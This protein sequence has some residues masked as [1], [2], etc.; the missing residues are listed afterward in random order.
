[1]RQEEMTTSQTRDWRSQ[2]KRIASILAIVLLV[3]FIALNFEKVDVDFLVA[4]QNIQLA[5]ALIFAALLGFVAGYFSP[6]WR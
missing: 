4:T 3:I 1:M 2:V 6:R 5:F